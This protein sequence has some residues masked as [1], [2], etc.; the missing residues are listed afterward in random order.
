M[1]PMILEI[2]W[3]K[4]CVILSPGSIKRKIGLRIGKMKALTGHGVV[5]T[6]QFLWVIEMAEPAPR[7]LEQKSILCR[8]D[9]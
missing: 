8:G 9:S 6:G 5:R 3:N 7:M 1:I 4:F 2:I